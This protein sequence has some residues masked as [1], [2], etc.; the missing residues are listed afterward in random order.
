MT[1]AQFN[2]NLN[3][4]IP[5]PPVPSVF[6]YLG[7]PQIT[8]KVQKTVREV[9]QIPLIQF[10]AKGLIDPVLTTVGLKAAPSKSLL[11]PALGGQPFGPPVAGQGLNPIAS[12]AAGSV[13]V[14]GA[15]PPPGGA[16]P[17]SP[18]PAPAEPVSPPPPDP[19]TLAAA[20]SAKESDGEVEAK[21]A[22]I[23]YLGQ[24]NC[25][26]YPEAID[27]LLGVLGDCNEIVRYEALRAL[28]GGAAAASRRRFSPACCSVSPG[29]PVRA[30]QKLRSSKLTATPNF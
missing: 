15:A 24:Q 26:C 29:S 16:S 3:A 5:A 11:P 22:A 25:V 9:G 30:E 28:R 1:R 8:A 20:L 7:V 23:R 12:G 6:D 2:G 17:G 21:V 19:A 14:S 18:E 27:S 10:A 4:A 13:P